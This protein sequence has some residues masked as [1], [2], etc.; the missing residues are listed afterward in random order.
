MA[1]GELEV[2]EIQLVYFGLTVYG[3]YVRPVEFQ[4]LPYTALPPSMQLLTFDLG[5]RHMR[6]R[7]GFYGRT[8][9]GPC[10]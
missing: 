8:W 7:V 3:M 5:L 9:F 1:S 10:L 6:A 2:S 4:L